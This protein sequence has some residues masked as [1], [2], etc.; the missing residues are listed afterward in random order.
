M[1]AILLAFGTLLA[2]GC[3]TETP[4]SASF[5]SE[6]DADA[7]AAAAEVFVS[8]DEPGRV[9]LFLD[10]PAPRVLFS[11]DQPI[12]GGLTPSYDTDRASFDRRLAGIVQTLGSFR[13]QYPTVYALVNPAVTNKA[14]L[15]AV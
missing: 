11:I 9:E 5:R 4:P 10:G 14:A 15:V 6:A 3:G 13:Q 1:K 12:Q 2:S 7:D 8:T